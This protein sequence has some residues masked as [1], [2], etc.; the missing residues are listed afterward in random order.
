LTNRFAKLPAREAQP[1]AATTMNATAHVRA[2]TCLDTTRFL[3]LGCSA[4]LIV[5]AA[6][7]AAA[8]QQVQHEQDAGHDH[9][10]Y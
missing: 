10:D 8:A 1:E 7:P 9:E 4:L 2:A 5:V 6:Q 3:L